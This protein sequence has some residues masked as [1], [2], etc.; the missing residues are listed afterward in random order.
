MPFFKNSRSMKKQ[1]PKK[2][3]KQIADTVLQEGV[4]FS[5]TINKPTWLHKVGL[6]P[7]KRNFNIKPLVTGVLL[8]ISKTIEDMKPM[9][10][11]GIKDRTLLEVGIDQAKY[12][13]HLIKIIAYAI[14]NGPGEPSKQLMKFLDRNLTP[15]EMMQV[16]NVVVRQMDVMSFLSSIMSVKGMSLLNPREKIALGD[17]SEE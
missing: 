10:E 4:D 14:Q 3:K 17:S 6:L 1:D 15:R 9:S 8:Q 7:S 5:I 13:D 12:K 11:E 16:L 2:V